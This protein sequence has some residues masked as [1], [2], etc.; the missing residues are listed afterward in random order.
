M[1]VV[2]VR[3]AGEAHE[4]KRA[5]QAAKMAARTAQPETLWN[6]PEAKEWPELRVTAE[7]RRTRSVLPSHAAAA[8]MGSASLERA[9]ACA[10]GFDGERFALDGELGAFAGEVESCG[11]EGEFRDP[12]GGEAEV[13][14][15]AACADEPWEAEEREDEEPPWGDGGETVDDAGTCDGED[16]AEAAEEREAEG[17][18]EGDVGDGCADCDP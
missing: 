2:V 11:G 10:G 18:A 8:R 1:T 4:R 17:F 12:C 5:R 9:E 13:P 16:P 3:W 15:E 6:Q 14:A 7:R